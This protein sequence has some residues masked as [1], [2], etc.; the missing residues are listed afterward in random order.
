MAKLAAIILI[1]VAC[2]IA[3][4]PATAAADST[5]EKYQKYMKKY[6]EHLKEAQ[7]EAAEGD[8]DDYY[9]E[10]E[11]AQE[12]FAK[13]QRYLS[14]IQST[15]PFYYYPAPQTYYPEMG[16]APGYIAPPPPY[17]A[18]LKPRRDLRLYFGFGYSP[19]GRY[20]WGC[21][22]SHKHWNG[23]FRLFFGR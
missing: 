17:C 6:Y 3:L 5:Y 12:D 1:A 23:M 9:E 19:Y 2:A 18:I 21:P 11:K 8:W 14:I 4:S 16:I 7:E 22:H 15:P 10:M 13:A 20:W